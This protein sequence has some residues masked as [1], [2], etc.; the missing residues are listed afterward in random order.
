MIV[1]S[2]VHVGLHL[3]T[4]FLRRRLAE[5]GIDRAVVFADPETDDL[6]RDE[7][8][9]LEF[10]ER[11]GHLPFYYHGGL[12]Y[13][14]SRPFRRITPPSDLSR[15]RGVKWH[16]WW[17]PAHDLGRG[18]LHMT[19]AEVEREVASGPFRDLMAALGEARRP[20][21]FEEHFDV[22]RAVVERY[23]DVAIVIPH[24]GLLNGGSAR[25]LQAFG[26]LPHVYFDTSIGLLTKEVVDLVGPSRILA[27]SDFPYG[28]PA[29][30]RRQVERLGLPPED[31][32]AILGG[33]LARLCGLEGD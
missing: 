29:D 25:V 28:D 9:V 6:S 14:T 30:V 27:A 26:R 17:T 3:P 16:C 7:A 31:A 11:H 10:A 4:D 8:F 5:E 1:D 32:A 13:S 20:M 21:I 19:A 23:R 24:L 15:Y 22:T 2:H 33:N 12:A 18:P